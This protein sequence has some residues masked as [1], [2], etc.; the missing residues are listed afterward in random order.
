MTPLW[1]FT[2]LVPPERR[3]RLLELTGFEEALEQVISATTVVVYES[4]PFKDSRLRG[5]K[6][7]SFT[8]SI[9]CDGYDAFFNSPIGYRAQYCFGP[10]SGQ[11]ANRQIINALK[12]RLLAFQNV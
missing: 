2:N 7:A 1:D 3:T 6:R 4:Q 9:D 10:E 11:T 12:P 5:C 8:L